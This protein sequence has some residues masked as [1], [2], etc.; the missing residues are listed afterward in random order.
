LNEFLLTARRQK[1]GPLLHQSI[2]WPPCC[3]VLL[4]CCLVVLSCLFV[5]SCNVSYCVVFHQRKDLHWCWKPDN[6]KQ[7]GRKNPHRSPR[8]GRCWQETP[9]RSLLWG[10]WRQSAGRSPRS[11]T[12]CLR[13]KDRI[14]Q[15]R[16][17][18]RHGGARLFTVISERSIKWRAVL[19]LKPHLHRRN[20]KSP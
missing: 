7:V 5:L 6:G 15:Q 4:C 10:H 13:R 1:C 19:L 12:G 2:I 14:R 18:Y 11:G 17:T 8:H 9:T 3:V 20:E 16:G